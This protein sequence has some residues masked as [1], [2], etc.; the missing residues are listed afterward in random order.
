MGLSIINAIQIM[1]HLLPGIFKPVLVVLTLMLATEQVGIAQSP[2]YGK[3]MRLNGSTD[4]VE[5]GNMGAMPE[6]GSITFWCNAFDLAGY[7]NV[8]TT[9]DL[10]GC[11]NGNNAVRFEIDNGKFGA[12]IMVK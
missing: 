2:N 4:Y 12:Q 9:G 3:A 7:R 8:L 11:N 6:K 5:A 1:K 10:S